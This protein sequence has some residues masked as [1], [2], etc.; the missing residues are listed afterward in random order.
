MKFTTGPAYNKGQT[1]GFRNGFAQRSELGPLYFLM[2][3]NDIG[4]VSSS[5]ELEFAA[6]TKLFGI[7]TI[8]QDIDRIREYRYLKICIIGKC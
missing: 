5:R 1:F 2:H 4:K 6:D 3:I 7:V 8:E